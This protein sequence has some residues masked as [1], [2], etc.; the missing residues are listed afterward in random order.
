[1]LL[2]L[3][4]LMLMMLKSM[5]IIDNDDGDDEVDD[6]DKDWA[7]SGDINEDDDFE[8]D[9]EEGYVVVNVGGEDFDAHDADES[10]DYCCD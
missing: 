7:A 2:L 8:V 1:M 9:V 3:L 4:M 6:V 5:T 10:D